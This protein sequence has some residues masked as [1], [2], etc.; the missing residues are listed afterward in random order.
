M[1]IRRA[2]EQAYKGTMLLQALNVS[3]LN[4][5]AGLPEED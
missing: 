4:V 1:T 3:V 2:I 5:S